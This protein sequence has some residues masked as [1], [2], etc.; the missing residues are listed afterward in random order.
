[1]PIHILLMGTI[2]SMCGHIY[3]WRFSSERRR[4]RTFPNCQPPAL[5]ESCATG[6]GLDVP[7]KCGGIATNCTPWFR[8][9]G[10][11]ELLLKRYI[12]DHENFHEYVNDLDYSPCVPWLGKG[13][14]KTAH[15]SMLTFQAFPPPFNEC[16]LRDARRGT[17][18]S[19][20]AVEDSIRK[21]HIL[22]GCDGPTSSLVLAPT[23]GIQSFSPLPKTSRDG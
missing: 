14:A 23:S 20:H 13:V 22:P 15:A 3:L 6:S 10:R 7:C 11:N 5:A 8:K 1:M 4:D 12:Y 9:K 16:R 18:G 21:G 17:L 2:Y 19:F